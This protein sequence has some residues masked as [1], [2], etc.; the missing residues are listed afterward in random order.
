MA[1]R[2]LGSPPMRRIPWLIC[3]FAL[4]VAACGGSPPAVGVEV[5][6]PES[7][8][9]AQGPAAPDFELALDDGGTF[10]LGAEQKPVYMVFWAEW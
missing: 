6:P 9:G 7:T 2:R 8:A 3:A 5:S 4:V 10:S 1:L